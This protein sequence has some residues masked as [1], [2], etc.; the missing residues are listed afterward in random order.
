MKIGKGAAYYRASR[1]DQK[2]AV[3]SDNIILLR[4]SAIIFMVSVPIIYDVH[5]SSDIPYPKLITYSVGIT[6]M[7]CLLL[8]DLYF[9]YQKHTAEKEKYKLY[10]IL[11]KPLP[12]TKQK[13]N[14]TVP[15]YI[16]V[17]CVMLWMI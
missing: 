15:Y 14:L 5:S 7:L 17:V 8:L 13:R 16:I 3:A 11:E 9:Q 2:I 6:V 10:E 12:E 4:I 1:M